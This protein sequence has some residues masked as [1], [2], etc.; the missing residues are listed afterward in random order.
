MTSNRRLPVL[1]SIL[2]ALGLTSTSA[3]H[4]R[5]SV[6]RWLERDPMQYRDGMDV[7]QSMS[8]R[9][10]QVVDAFGREAGEPRSRNASAQLIVL[11]S[12][13]RNP[14]STH[15]STAPMATNPSSQSAQP[16]YP[17][18]RYEGCPKNT[19]SLEDC[20][21]CAGKRRDD[22]LT[23]CGPE[24]DPGGQKREKCDADHIGDIIACSNLPLKQIPACVKKANR[25]WEQCIDDIP[26]SWTYCRTSAIS[27]YYQ[28][29]EACKEWYAPI[30]PW[31][32]EHSPHSPQLRWRAPDWCMPGTEL[33]FD[34][35]SK[36]N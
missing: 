6:G 9:P 2:I 35:D 33:R 5:P 32:E 24:A 29:V 20:L 27:H 11:L 19:T 1:F 8:S 23:R 12:R 16:L 17:L 21:K 15:P 13:S 10:T 14:A 25:K 31:P 36:P 22:D 28:E 4:Y 34:H 30:F 18:G 7:Y 3:A 26:G